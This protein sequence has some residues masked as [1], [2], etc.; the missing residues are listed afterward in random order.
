MSVP[1]RRSPLARMH[2]GLGASFEAEAG[3][4]VVAG[5]GDDTAERQAVR[6]ALAVVDVTPRGKVDVRGA[7][8]GAL[9]VVG[10]AITA[11]VSDQWALV[12]TEPGGEEVLLPKIESAAASSAMV[13][14]A[15]H[16]FAGLALAGPALPEVL[17]LLTSWDPASLSPGASTGA[18]IGDVRAV[19]V[20][21]DLELPVLE[22]YVATEFARYLGE[23]VLDAAGRVGGA[24][25]GWRALKAGGWS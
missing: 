19:V 12:F 17:S 6:E 25:A 13:T 16:L 14:D 11:R 22:V 18:P 7:L 20:R 23:T 4:E 3:W 1:I 10:D 9:S 2:E 15:T 21:R 8:A 24:P 5:Y